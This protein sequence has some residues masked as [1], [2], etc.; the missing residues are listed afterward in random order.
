M[1]NIDRVTVQTK[2]LMITQW[3]A[4]RSV[5]PHHL[6]KRLLDGYWWFSSS[7]SV[8][9]TERDAVLLYDWQERLSHINLLPH[10]LSPYMHAGLLE[11][12]QNEEMKLWSR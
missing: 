7:A 11:A 5:S 4:H 8:L 6:Q 9:Q 1:Y 3:S 2:T 10:P 12:W